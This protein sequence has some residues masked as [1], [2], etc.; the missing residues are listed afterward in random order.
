MLHTRLLTGA[1]TI[2]QLVADVPRGLSLVPPQEIK[3]R[4]KKASTLRATATQNPAAKQIE[5]SAVRGH[6]LVRS[7]HI[8]DITL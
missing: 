6:G 4:N 3:K 2:G 7:P 5:Q 8:R 1:G